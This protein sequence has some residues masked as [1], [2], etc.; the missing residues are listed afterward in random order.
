LTLRKPSK[1]VHIL[2]QKYYYQ[3]HLGEWPVSLSVVPLLSAS[4]DQYTCPLF[5]DSRFSQ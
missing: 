4:G 2:N 1:N 3:K 5:S